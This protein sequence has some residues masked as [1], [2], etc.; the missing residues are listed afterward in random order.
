[1]NYYMFIGGVHLGPTQ[2]AGITQ[3]YSYGMV[4]HLA[5]VRLL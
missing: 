3:A 2:G 5:G 4:A 1:M